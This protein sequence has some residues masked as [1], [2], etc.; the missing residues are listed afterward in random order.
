VNVN[1]EFDASALGAPA[2]FRNAVLTAVSFLDA[3]LTDNITVNIA[4]GYGEINGTALPNQAGAEGTTSGGHIYSYSSISGLLRSHALPG[5]HTFDA[6]P[7]G[8]SIQGQTQVAVWSAEEKA[9]GLIGANGGA[10]DGAIGIGTNLPA[11]LVV[12]ATLHEIGHAMGRIPDGPRPDIFDLFRF[13]S[14]GTRLF[15]SG[16]TAP[17]AY[18]SVDG[19]ATDLANYGQ[20]SDASDFLN[21]STPE[22]PLD[23][24]YDSGTLQYL[25]ALDLKQFDATGFNFAAPNIGVN[26]GPKVA[27]TPDDF[28]AD[29]TGD[30][31]WR[32]A[33]GALADW[34][35][36][37]ATIASGNYL[38]SGGSIAAPDASWNVAAVSDFNN[39]GRA[40]LL[41][42]NTSGVLSMWA[43][44]GSTITASAFVTLGGAIVAPDASWKIAG[45]GDFNADGASDLLWRNSSGAT[46]LWLM[47]GA[48]IASASGIFAGGVA[49]NPDP[50]WTVAG[51]GDFN[52]DNHADILWR[53]SSGAVAVWTM[54]GANVT[55]G[56]Y[57][58][59]NGAVAAP[60]ASW[61]VA[62]IG[63]FNGD[64]T[65]DVLWRNANGS[66][67]EWLM[68]GSTIIGNGAV[69]SNGVPVAPG[70]N[71]HIVDVADF[72]GDGKTDILW[73]DDSGTVV[74]W[75]MNGT[76]ITS[77][78][79]LASPDLS[80][81]VQNKPTNY[82]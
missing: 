74:Q 46:A 26:G 41:W 3:T 70:A 53:N 6:L 20:T 27:F 68:N 72:N 25:T 32:N 44:N 78:N 15:Q 82:A 47:N 7:A 80:W 37:G 67:V 17:P 63:D 66:L 23:E 30:V 31:L 36:N 42:Q 75:L 58:T 49:V 57:A 56:A 5:D 55:S 18:F 76:Q 24:F 19:G 52:A 48:A 45:V 73:R 22:D 29:F 35:M 38:T 50:S 65:A 51:I 43:M 14:P 28:G 69:T 12:S 39:D 21:S 40:D 11:S 10:L 2:S 8:S 33:N 64:H 62:G 13:T 59:Y 60:D 4:V 34:E 16:D 54:N 79:V 9:L 71:W 1:V 77:S 81:S 61:S